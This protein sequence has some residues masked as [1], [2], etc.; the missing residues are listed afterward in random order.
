MLIKQEPCSSKQCESFHRM[1]NKP[2]KPTYKQN[3]KTS[4]VHF[5]QT[6]RIWIITKSP[7]KKMMKAFM[8]KI[9]PNVKCG[10]L[11]HNGD[12]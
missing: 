10:I 5:I 4:N 8:Y 7:I 1:G 11:S 9:Y 12:L 3:E 6:E 2:T